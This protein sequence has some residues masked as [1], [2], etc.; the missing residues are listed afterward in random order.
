MDKKYIDREDYCKNVCKCNEKL[1]DKTTCPIWN[2]PI[3][4]VVNVV[5]CKD[6][7]FGSGSKPSLLGFVRCAH[8]GNI[9]TSKDFCSYGKLAYEKFLEEL[10]NTENVSADDLKAMYEAY[11]NDSATE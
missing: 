7:K 10:G 1:C 2:T 6:C 9:T 4:D 5:R 8:W 3:A 11:L